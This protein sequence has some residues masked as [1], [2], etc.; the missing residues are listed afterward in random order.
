MLNAV[1]A[2]VAQRD[3]RA[4][5]EH[6]IAAWR[7]LAAHE[8]VTVAE[9]IGTRAAHG[10]QLPITADPH[11]EWFAAAA[12]GDLVLRQRLVET[13]LESHLHER[14]LG[15]LRAL[16]P[17]RD[18]RLVRVLQQMLRGEPTE[19]VKE[20]RLP[21][22]ALVSEYGDPNTPAMLDAMERTWTYKPG[23]AMR[24][25]IAKLRA[26]FSA[27]PPLSAEQRALV[28][29]ITAALPP[30]VV[31]DTETEAALLAA[32]YADPASDGPRAIYA[33]WLQELGDPRGEY[34]ALELGPEY[35]PRARELCHRYGSEWFGDLLPN[36]YVPKFTRGFLSSA[37]LRNATLAPGWATLEW[38]QSKLP[39]PSL[40]VLREAVSLDAESFVRLAA[41]A[42][43][44]PLE[45][46]SYSPGND[47][48]EANVTAAATALAQVLPRIPSLVSLEIDE[49]KPRHRLPATDPWPW[50]N[51][52]IR[53]L[54]MSVRLEDLG[55]WLVAGLDSQLDKLTVQINRFY[56]WTIKLTRAGGFAQLDVRNDEN[57]D[58]PVR[59]AMPHV[60]AGLLQLPASTLGSL[61]VTITKKAWTVPIRTQYAAVL[62]KHPTLT[63]QSSLY[64]PVTRR[65]RVET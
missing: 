64:K 49:V 65:R 13:V 25:A 38:V 16:I 27:P 41:M 26:Q 1:L 15:R 48:T 55:P 53:E 2:A 46:I 3:Y 18:P 5:L 39:G 63:K 45:R 10:I 57:Y 24:T 30:V 44:P 52:S 6:V 23:P 54:L 21:L 61:V 29:A 11:A 51:T 56:G 42:T 8:L 17:T 59:E 36:V 28:A 32:I 37:Q 4:A 35:S 34:I 22:L 14:Q 58:P 9:A 33:D 47:E 20:Y 12:A 19:Y 31:R 40:P 50:R 62:A 43:P 7:E 60:L